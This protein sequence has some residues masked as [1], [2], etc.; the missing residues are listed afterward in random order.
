MEKSGRTVDEGPASGRHDEDGAKGRTWGRARSD[1]RM[2]HGRTLETASGR[3][4]ASV[5]PKKSDT[6]SGTWTEAAFSRQRTTVVRGVGA[7][8]R[9]PL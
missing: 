3:P 7:A 9:R 2:L 4:D 6:L 1:G 8:V 5:A